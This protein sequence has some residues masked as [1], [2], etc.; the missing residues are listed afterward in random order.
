M[1]LH[2]GAGGRAPSNRGIVNKLA[3]PTASGMST[4][5]LSK[6]ARAAMLDELV[7]VQCMTL[8][9]SCFHAG[10]QEASL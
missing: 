4:K 6:G 7:L 8:L 2:N 10:R 5:K 3:D 1:L 9:I